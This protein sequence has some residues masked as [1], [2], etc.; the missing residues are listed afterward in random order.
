MQPQDDH[1]GGE[2][3]P[4]PAAAPLQLAIRPILPHEEDVQRRFFNGLSP[5]SRFARF[6]RPISEMPDY[7]M[8]LLGS[9][10]NRRHVAFMAEATVGRRR[11]MV[12]EARFV[13]SPDEPQEC[14]FAITVADA[15]QG[16]GI[17]GSLLSCLEARARAAGI[18]HMV[19][20]TTPGNG[21]MLELARRFGYAVGINFEEPEMKRLYK[22]LTRGTRRRR[23]IH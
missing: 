16:R 3:L 10:D 19:A 1:R 8:K 5:R 14:E 7:M 17:A 15:W 6:M 18:R 4:P 2:A 9:I 23:R 11:V 13:I 21:P 12:G 22:D 20:D